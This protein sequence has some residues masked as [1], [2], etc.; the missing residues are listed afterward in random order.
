[1]LSD[2]Y[3]FSIIARDVVRG[4]NPLWA[5]KVYSFALK[6]DIVFYLKADVPHLVSRMVYGRGFDYWESGMDIRCADN[7][8]DSFCRY[9]SL[10]IDQYDG[11][12]NE[13]GFTTVDATRSVNEVFED[14]RTSI[15]S[16]LEE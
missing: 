5:R 2:R 6:P 14:L 3:F 7:L 8:Y 16:L 11:M 12:A 13:F 9:Q 10:L 1:M 4:A 15:K